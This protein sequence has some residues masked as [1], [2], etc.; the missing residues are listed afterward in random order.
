MQ[1]DVERFFEACF[2]EAGW[3]FEPKGRHSDI[4][5]I[6]GVYMSGGCMWCLYAGGKVVGTVAVRLIDRV[7]NI[8][9][10]KRLYVLKEHQGK[11]YG[12]ML[13]KTAVD[14]AG[15]KKYAAIRAD[16]Q[17]KRQAARHLMQKYGFCE[18]PRYNDNAFAELFYEL[19]L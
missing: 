3:I 18:I 5:D 10:L 16:T 6:G 8:A 11:N 12:D 4:M 19:A 14:F 2:A 7:N 1:P 15:E 9:E 13:F 17:R